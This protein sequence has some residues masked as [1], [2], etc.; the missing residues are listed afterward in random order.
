MQQNAKSRRVI[1]LA[2]QHLNLKIHT[3]I[4]YKELKKGRTLYS[5]YL[6]TD[7]AMT[8]QPLFSP[9]SHG[10]SV[11]F[12]WR[13]IKYCLT[14]ASECSAVWLYGICL[15]LSVR[16]DGESH[17]VHLPEKHLTWVCLVP[18]PEKPWIIGKYDRVD[19]EWDNQ[20]QQYRDE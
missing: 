1:K 11:D 5:N 16:C 13:K 17:S 3:Y 2:L 20:E 19:C 7:Q 8:F 10:Y 9:Q 6:A 15:E 14:F 12:W 4:L 18:N